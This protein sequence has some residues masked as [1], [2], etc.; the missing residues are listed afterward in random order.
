MPDV[1]IPNDPGLEVVIKNFIG[2]RASYK[3]EEIATIINWVKETMARASTLRKIL[4]GKI[5]IDV[6]R[7]GIVMGYLSSRDAIREGLDEEEANRLINP[8][9]IVYTDI[10]S[11]IE[12]LRG[13]DTENFLDMLEELGFDESDF[14][15]D[16]GD[17]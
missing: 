2:G 1:P 8:E 17:S 3:A 16:E 13:M 4:S 14:E 7:N 11:Y 5:R 10:T 6:D 15:D 9:P 12:I